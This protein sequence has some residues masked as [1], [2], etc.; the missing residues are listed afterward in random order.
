M[1]DNN[2]SQQ[3]PPQQ[4][5]DET[6]HVKEFEALQAVISARLAESAKEEDASQL[7]RAEL[8]AIRF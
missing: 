3:E 5:S 1:F 6:D 4:S 2:T 7:T 8:E